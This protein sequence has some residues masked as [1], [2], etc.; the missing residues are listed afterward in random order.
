VIDASVIIVNFRTADDVL[1]CVEGLA[2]DPVREVIVIDNSPEE[3]LAERLP[4]RILYRAMQRNVGFA[5]AVNAAV[6]ISNGD[7]LILLNP[8]ARPQRGCFQGLCRALASGHAVAAPA[9][10]PFDGGAAPVPCATQRDPDLC[11]T[12]VEHTVLRRAVA[13]DWLHRNYFLDARESSPRTCAMVQGACLAVHRSWMEKLGGLDERFCLYWEDTDFCR[14]VRDRGGTVLFSPDLRCRH[15]GGA[16]LGGKQDARRFWQGLYAYH[17]KHSGHLKTAVLRAAVFTG[18]AGEWLILT[19]LHVA[20]RGR[21]ST[22]AA[23][24]R[25]MLEK[26]LLQLRL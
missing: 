18:I 8:D 11:T 6:D 17:R 16:S 3:G 22:L 7:L 5:A 19:S 25:A 14:R 9:L 1:S 24:R 2:E 10:L 13:P 21:D 23:D 4:A 20:R 12:L 26:M 15:A